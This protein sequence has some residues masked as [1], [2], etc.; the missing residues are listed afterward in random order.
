V[1]RRQALKHETQN[2]LRPFEIRIV[3]KLS[4]NE[5]KINPE[6]GIN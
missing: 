5:E 2:V 1:L 6:G 4:K 3:Y